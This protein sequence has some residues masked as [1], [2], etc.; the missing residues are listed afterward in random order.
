MKIFSSCPGCHE[1]RGSLAEFFQSI[2]KGMMW[3]YN[4]LGDDGGS[5]SHLLRIGPINAWSVLLTAK[6]IFLKRGNIET[7][8]TV[9]TI[10]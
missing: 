10:E 2:D 3:W 7:I 8:L 1:V 5:I 9:K 6:I 4:M